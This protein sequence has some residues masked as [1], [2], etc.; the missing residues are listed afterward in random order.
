VS[1]DDCIWNT[2]SALLKDFWKYSIDIHTY[3]FFLKYSIWERSVAGG[4]QHHC[5]VPASSAKQFRYLSVTFCLSRVIIQ[6][7]FSFLKHLQRKAKFQEQW[8]HD[9][10]SKEK[11]HKGNFII[12]QPF[13]SL[14]T[15]EVLKAPSLCLLLTLSFHLRKIWKSVVIQ[16]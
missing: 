9:V 10:F 3:M 8:L 13:S 12:F 4:Q 2:L 15:T 14:K 16:G 5:A 7:C 11:Q 1:S 6:Q